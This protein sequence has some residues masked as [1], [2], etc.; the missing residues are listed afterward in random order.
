MLA[1]ILGVD[2]GHAGADGD[3]MEV[4]NDEDAEEDDNDDETEEDS[5]EARGCMRPFA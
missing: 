2:D 1:V 5:G 4:D 3:G